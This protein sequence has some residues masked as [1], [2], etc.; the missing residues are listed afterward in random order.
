MLKVHNFA[1]KKNVGKILEI[2]MNL[3]QIKNQ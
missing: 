1:T 3:N 2:G